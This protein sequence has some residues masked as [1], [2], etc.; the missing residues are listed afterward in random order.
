M[1]GV[2]TPMLF[3]WVNDHELSEESVRAITNLSLTYREKKAS[4]GSLTVVD[5]HF[6]FSDNKIFQQG[7]RLAFLFGWRD[8][9]LPCGPFVI[10]G[11]SFNASADGRPTLR[12]DFQDLSHKLDKKTKKRKHVGSPVDVIK[13]IADEHN[14]GYDIES[15]Q[16]L[17]FSDDYPLIQA[18]M[19]DAK[20]LQVLADRYGY[21]WGL[22]GTTIYFRRPINADKVGR[23]DTV[24]VLSYRING[25]TL[26]SF[27]AEVSYIKDGKKKCAGQETDVMDM[28]G[29][30][31]ASV[32]GDTLDTVAEAAENLVGSEVVSSVRDTAGEALSGFKDMLGLEDEKQELCDGGEANKDNPTEPGAEDQTG[33]STPAQT[34]ASKGT[35]YKKHF[36]MLKGMFKTAKEVG[37]SLVNAGA[38]DDSLTDSNTDGTPDSA[39][40]AK[41]KQAGKLASRTEMIEATIVPA[42]AS[43]LYRPGESVIVAGVGDRYSGKYRI[44]EVTHDYGASP[45]FTTSIK[46]KKREFRPAA[47][48]LIAIAKQQEDSAAKVP[49]N[50]NSASGQPQKGPKT[51][52][53]KNFDDIK[54]VYQT[55]T[56]KVDGNDV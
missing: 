3:V 28:V 53:I 27:S 12:V 55:V 24:P 26:M 21:T 18:N 20:L 51:Q 8:E 31:L 32:G 10:K 52:Q 49:G 56:R 2:K 36:E 42:I 17:E 47:S 14:L 50:Q 13:K 22:D 4:D 37:K 45:A 1:P 5:S 48:D 30:A 44:S 11:Y 25:G 6:K 9:A 35:S 16:E 29:G 46:A 54:G 38:D 40:E 41:R 23:Q 19:S 15:I 39:D 34:S 7:Q 33:D 43:L